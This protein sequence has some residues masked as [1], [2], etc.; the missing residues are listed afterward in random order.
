MIAGARD[1]DA[2]RGA[3]GGNEITPGLRRGAVTREIVRQLGQYGATE[4]TYFRTRLFRRAEHDHS[5]CSVEEAGVAMPPIPTMNGL[6][7][8]MHSPLRRRIGSC[9]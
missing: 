4:Q 7:I 2:V 6:P 5:A 9:E 8:F 1:D 3:H